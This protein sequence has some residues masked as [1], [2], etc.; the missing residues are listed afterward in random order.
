VTAA[1]TYLPRRDLMFTAAR[2]Q[3]A[4]L[5]GEPITASPT[6]DLDQSEI[7]A[8]RPMLRGDFWKGGQP[9]AFERVYR[10]SLAYR[11]ACVARGTFDGMLTLRPSWEWDIAAGALI[12]AEAGALCTDRTGAPL[13]FNNPT[14]KL[15]GVVA[16]NRAIHPQILAALA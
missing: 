12:L 2:G 9:P 6:R 16:G 10:A 15:N 5:N 4:Y 8:A 14:P 1:V 3:G 7:L 13:R 11:M